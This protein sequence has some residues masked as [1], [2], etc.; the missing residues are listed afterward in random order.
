MENLDLAL[1]RGRSSTGRSGGRA[2][3]RLH[4]CAGSAGAVPRRQP[5]PLPWP[6]VGRASQEDVRNR[7][8]YRAQRPQAHEASSLL[9]IPYSRTRA[10]L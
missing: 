9:P 7:Y 4:K 3:R 1:H 6:R 5:L 8:P 10:C 2:R